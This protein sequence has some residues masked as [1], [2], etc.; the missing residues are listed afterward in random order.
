MIMVDALRHDYI[1]EEDSPFLHGLSRQGAHGSLIPSFGFEPDGA[2][3]AGLDPEECDGGAQYW[4]NPD[5]RVFYFTGLFRVL[6]LL[7]SSRWRHLLRKAIRL[8]AQL[9]ARDPMTRR[10]APPNKI[11]LHMLE[12]FSFPMTHFAHDPG[13]TPGP[14]VFDIARKHKLDFL[15]HGHPLYKVKTPRVVERYL[16]DDHGQHALSF[17]FMGDLDGIGHRFGPDS[18]ERRTML[19]EVDSAISSIYR[20]AQENYGEVDL[21]VFGDHGMVAV[22][23][24]IDTQEMIRHAETDSE[25]DSYFLDSTFARF[26]LKPGASGDRLR[27]H[28]DKIENGHVLSD[29]E[30]KEYRIRFPHNYFGDVI[31]VADDA[32]L[33]HPS[34]YAEGS[35]APC[36]MHGYL[37]GCRDNESAFVL[38]SQRCGGAGDLGRIDMRRVFPTILELLD[39][40]EHHSAPHEL[41]SF[42]P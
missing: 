17:L 29:S 21:L 5:D 8:A 32:K 20:H 39:V 26:W 6:D 2:Y 9:M 31:F 15:F 16:N 42:I 24:I 14:T 10:M 34:F 7:P 33:I 23:G 27:E 25:V 38:S 4:R 28:L 41:T 11:P 3:F 1:T 37:P 12:Q 18:S 36:G 30:I 35:H 40:P 13:F 22:D 19:R